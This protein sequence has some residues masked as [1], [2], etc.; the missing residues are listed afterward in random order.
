[1]KKIAL[2]AKAGTTIFASTGMLGKGH[3]DRMSTLLYYNAAK[4]SKV[5]LL[6]P[7][8]YFNIATYALRFDD[9]YI[10]T[11]CY[12]EEQSWTTYNQDL[13]GT[14]YRQEDYV[15]DDE[16]YFRICLKRVDG[17]AFTDDEAEHV[18]EIVSFYSSV[19]RVYREK[20]YFIKEAQKTAQTIQDKRTPESLVFGV[21]TDTHVAVNGTWEDTAH[22]MKAVHEKAGFD[23]IVHLGDLTDGMVPASVTK[24]YVET[25]IS[26]LNDNRVP[27]FVVLGNHDSNYFYNNPEPLTSDEQIHTYLRRSDSAVEREPENDYYYVDFQPVSLRCLFLSSFDYREKVRYGYSNEELNWVRET[28]ISAPEGYSFIV[29]SHAPPLP[30]LDYSWTDAIRNGEQLLSI[31]EKYGIRDGKKVLAF[32]HGHTHADY[33]YNERAFPI[34]SIGC[35]K[36]EQFTDNK[37]DGS[38]TWE[39]K[40]YT[41]TQ[42]LWDT[43]IITPSAS[44]IDFVRFGAGED[45]T[46][47]LGRKEGER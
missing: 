41:V 15:F 13:S 6:N 16:V 40:L 46:V 12:H 34:V 14:T 27:L 37:P 28:L 36:C 31:L 33:V 3:P 19:E 17:C 47:L 45:R 18:N 44:K 9:K 24:R 26:D 38:V 8:Y 2:E 7:D 20:F 21:V 39:R 25:V 35:A 30:L 5:C 4:G 23:A 10:Y 1:M 42:E 43:L 32:I 22:N 11:F 29:F